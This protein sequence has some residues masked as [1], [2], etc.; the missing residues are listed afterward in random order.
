[1]TLARAAQ[2]P[3]FGLLARLLV[4]AGPDAGM[5]TVA[6]CL[7]I[8]ALTAIGA[9]RGVAFSLPHWVF[10]ALSLPMIEPARTPVLARAWWIPAET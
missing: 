9:S 10:R 5:M 4:V 1:M 8:V 7:V 2:L 3:A 6:A